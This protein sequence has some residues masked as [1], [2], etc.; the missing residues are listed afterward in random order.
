MSHAITTKKEIMVNRGS[1]LVYPKHESHDK[2]FIRSMPI[3][4]PF[5]GHKLPLWKRTMD[6]I[7][8]ILGL[9]IF[10]PIM[11]SISLMIKFVS[12]GP[13]FFKQERVGYGGKT[14]MMWKFRSMKVDADT[15]IHQDHLSELHKNGKPMN[16]VGNDQFIIPFGKIL[17][18]TCLDELPQLINV[19]LGEM[20]LVGPRPD[21]V[22]SVGHYQNWY[23]GRFDTIPGMTG[24]WQV[25][26]KYKTTF[27][28]MMRLDIAYSRRKSFWM[29]FKILLKT[30]PA[31]ILNAKDNH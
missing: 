8:A 4:E 2:A 27:E 13:V 11:L 14:F 9:I 1:E 10:S 30:V 19:I 12:P 7:G 22:Y 18:K 29:D 31:I 28:E 23:K 3:L 24:L 16:K 21:P 5:F 26:G 20:S 15:S 25:N 6:V 17:R